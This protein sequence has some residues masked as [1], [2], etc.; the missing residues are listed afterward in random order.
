MVN[1]SDSTPVPDP[2]PQPTPDGP[3]LPIPQ[4][5]IL[6]REAMMEGTN[7]PVRVMV[8]LRIGGHLI[9]GLVSA[10]VVADASG[11]LNPIMMLELKTTWPVR[12]VDASEPNVL[13][14]TRMPPEP[15]RGLRRL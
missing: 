6:Y 1:G 2:A 13:T 10:N 7:T 4:V 15:P 11:G 5:D 14:A 3:Q 12:Y 9:G 8:G